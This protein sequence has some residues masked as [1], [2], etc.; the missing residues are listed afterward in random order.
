[1]PRKKVLVAMSGGVDSSVA[2]ALLKEEGHEVAGATI[3]TWA[4]DRCVERNTRACCGLSGV[5]DAREVADTLGIPYWVFN[6]EKEFKTH[7][8]DY[9][10]S[11]YVKGRTPNPCIACNEHVKFRLFLA[12][13]RQLGFE[14][15]ATGHYA[16]IRFH[17][18]REAYTVA[19][20]RDPVKDQSYVL[21]PLSQDVLSH[22]MLPL[23]RFAKSEIRDRARR[24]GLCVSEKP[25]SQEIC[26][27]PS[28]RYGEFV[29][30][31]ITQARPANGEAPGLDAPRPGRVRTREG[32]ILG[33][34]RGYFHYTRGQRRG[35]GIPSRE[36]LYV[37]E[38]LPQTNE[39]VVGTKE[40]V[41]GSSCVVGRVNWFLRPETSAPLRAF[42][43]IRSQHRKAPAS[44]AILE[45]DR[46]RVDFEDPQD[47]I[48]PGQGAAFYHGSEIFGGGWIESVL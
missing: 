42:V 9:F 32:K 8:V 48:T 18:S 40:E 1:M 46:V 37:L 11:D 29:E 44:L 33:A 15:M 34:H 23:G 47:A 27:I 30:G 7:V 14:A 16:G 10:V 22:L 45:G 4:P 39:V 2:A 20:G 3:R 31:R 17:P 26:F 35:L 12:R 38:T 21:F 6:F 13:A 24:L 28:N 43:K 19:E 41:F 36:R 5:E 25:D